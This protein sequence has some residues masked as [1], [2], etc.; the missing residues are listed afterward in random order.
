MNTSVCPARLGS[1]TS[2]VALVRT[3]SGYSFPV[4]QVCLDASFDQADREPDLEP[5]HW[6]WIAQPATTE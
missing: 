4:C 3:R 1:C 2:V 5:T 6:W